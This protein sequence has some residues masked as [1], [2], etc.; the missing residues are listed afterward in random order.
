MTG[1]EA[2]VLP[3]LFFIT[4]RLTIKNI[5]KWERMRGKTFSEMSYANKEDVL[6]LLYVT[7]GKDNEC[8]LSQY[9]EAVTRSPILRKEIKEIEK[10]SAILRQYEGERAE[11]TG[12]SKGNAS[13]SEMAGLLAMAGIDTAY[14]MNEMRID[15]IPVFM[16]AYERKRKEEM[17]QQRINTWFTILPHVNT[18]KLR[19]PQDLYTFPWEVDE[20]KREMEAQTGNLN[21]FLSGEMLDITKVKKRPRKR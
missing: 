12:E 1:R 9:K 15:E 2:V 11:T 19:R 17:E 14:L 7:S 6:T 10:E 16:E 20:A 8:T 21:K 3:P 18:K 5:I 4:M 13:V